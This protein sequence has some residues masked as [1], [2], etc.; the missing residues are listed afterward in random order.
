MPISGGLLYQADDTLVGVWLGKHKEKGRCYSLVCL[1]SSTSAQNSAPQL[2]TA[3]T[4]I[5][6]FLGRECIQQL[7]RSCCKAQRHPDLGNPAAGGV[8]HQQ[9]SEGEAEL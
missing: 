4:C 7:T 3:T 8:L 9:S 1:R 2:W 6:L 5:Q